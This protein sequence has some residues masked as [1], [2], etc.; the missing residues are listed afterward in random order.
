MCRVSS[1][2]NVCSCA[3]LGAVNFARETSPDGAFFHTGDRIADSMASSTKGGG[4]LNTMGVSPGD[5]ADETIAVDLSHVDTRCF[6]V[7]LMVSCFSGSLYDLE[8]VAIRVFAHQFKRGVW[9]QHEVRVTAGGRLQCL[10]S[11]RLASLHTGRLLHSRGKRYQRQD[12]SANRYRLDDWEDVAQG[13]YFTPMGVWG[14]R[15]GDEGRG[16]HE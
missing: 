14:G 8:S 5:D 2:R 10:D 3:W 11:Q 6:A 1:H 7:A 12:V 16:E 15:T 13:Q 4:S 9:Q